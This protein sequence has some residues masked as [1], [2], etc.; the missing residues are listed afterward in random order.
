[1][2]EL[3]CHWCG[4]AGP[5]EEF[6]FDELHNKGFW[7]PDCDNFTFFDLAEQETHRILLLL[8]QGGG[9]RE[10]GGKVQTGLRKRLSP[11]R[12]PGGKSKLIDFIYE[13][14][15]ENQM[16]TFVEVFAGGASLGLSL[17]DASKI[18]KLVLN[19][20]DPAVYAFWDTVVSDSCLLLHR[21]AE[22]PTYQDFRDA[23]LI[24]DSADELVGTYSGKRELAWSF[25]LLNRTCFSG[26]VKAGPMGGKAAD[27]KAFLSRWNSD[28]LR[29]RIG[30][31][32]ELSSRIEVHRMDCC[33]FVE[34][35]AYWYPDAT[36]FVD[37]PYY[38]KG[39]VLY[40]LS[41]TTAD[42][43]R[44]AD[45]LNAL[46]I[47]M[48]GPD[49]IVTYDDCPEIRNLYPFATVEEVRRVYSIAN[50]Q[51]SQSRKRLAFT[52]FFPPT[53]HEIDFFLFA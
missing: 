43:C 11:L 27:K 53:Q 14:L 30:R 33:D 15:Q 47:G 37:P 24:L 46:H 31:I 36:L 26:I 28:A 3:T 41:F 34:S 50:R 6:E 20:L 49:I 52:I 17:L 21:L 4:L 45:T 9:C 12:Y 10:S 7:C 22:A 18:N 42:H 32:S 23:K 44:L 51:E 35:L 40:P 5:A 2:R 48:P 39:P 25:L 1:M 13:R 16:D 29:K 38:Q 8:E 19:D